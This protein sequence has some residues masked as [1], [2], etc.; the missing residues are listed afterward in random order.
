MMQLTNRQS[1]MVQTF[2]E[3][4]TPITAKE[5]STRL[6]VS[7]RT[8]RYDLDAVE[9]W[10]KTK[11]VKLLRKPK[12]G[13]WID[14]EQANATEIRKYIS[15]NNPYTIVLTQEERVFY[16]LLELLKCDEV[17]T[18]DGI[19]EKLGVSRATIIKDLKEVKKLVVTNGLKL[20]SRQGVGYKV[21][22]SEEDIRKLMG[23]LFLYF[24]DTQ[25]LLK[26]LSN[27]E[28]ELIFSNDHLKEVSM[29]VNIAEIKKAIKSSKKV[30]SFWIP[31]SSYVALV[32][33]ILIALYRLL[34]GLKIEIPRER[35]EFV[36][37]NTEYLI[38]KEIGS[39]LSN[40]YNIEIP[41]AE[42]ANI[43]IHLL[44]ANL[45]LENKENEEVTENNITIIEIAVTE[46][47]QTVEKELILSS[48]SLQS[49][50]ADLVSH[51]KLSMKKYKLDID[52]ENPFLD[53]IKEGYHNLYHLAEKM[54]VVY[55][56]RTNI[57]LSE[58]EIGY[59]ALYL[60]VYKERSKGRGHKKTL[61][62]CSTGK[63]SAQIL[64]TKVKNNLPELEILD[65]ISIF[66]LEDK[67]HLI[68]EV[69]FIISTIDVHV[70]NKPVFKVNPFITNNELN[71]IR[72]NIY[73]DSDT[74][75]QKSNT[76]KSKDISRKSPVIHQHKDNQ[77]LFDIKTL[78]NFAEE[79]AF[80]LS[81]IANYT[82]QINSDISNMNV[83]G[84]TIHTTLAI[85]RWME[86]DFN[87]EIN[88]EDF[89]NKNQENYKKTR[90]IFDKIGQ[91]LNIDIPD[92]EVIALMRYIF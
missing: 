39:Y 69:D 74:V 82:Q 63:G 3:E 68:D 60:A 17:F 65:V 81:E 35:I 83:W 8:I 89:I 31:D 40:T 86:K 37:E 78:K 52:T 10:L 73:K 36:K 7:T 18:S 70:S 6:G 91:R 55:T 32:V 2:L 47:L 66:E 88:G 11:G 57:V 76:Q 27:F 29:S 42:I 90:E 54:A 92:S 5:L 22:G 41:E 20:V 43:T 24:E 51:L 75:T 33:H 28:E 80:I 87:T 77:I 67:N 34:N 23:K 1:A 72:N 4:K 44:S 71:V 48:D 56:K 38:A 26:L 64:A 58:H 13:I 59:I 30:Y 15:T 12:I 19:S 50:K 14:L 16:I 21:E 9:F 45:K 62:V 49:L 46:M 84:I 85:P 53:Q 61:I 79:T 25:N